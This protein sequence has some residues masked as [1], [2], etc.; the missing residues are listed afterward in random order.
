M[1][2]SI[3]NWWEETVK[4]LGDIA[5]KLSRSPLGIIALAFVFMYA[6]AALV[7]T[8]DL[9]DASD[10]SKFVWMLVILPFLLLA[11]LY[12]LITS[13]PTKLYAPSDFE[14]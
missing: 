9:L 11:G 12:R 13:H 1:S 7:A 6:I 4:T 14:D 5:I 8:S 10:R 3:R 2:K